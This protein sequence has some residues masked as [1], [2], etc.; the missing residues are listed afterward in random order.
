MIPENEDPFEGDVVESKSQAFSTAAPQTEPISNGVG[1]GW[2]QILSAMVL[3]RI[4]DP[5]YH[6]KRR[7]DLEDDV[8]LEP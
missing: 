7:G 3:L 2:G 1:P 5:A 4:Q 8:I 6:P